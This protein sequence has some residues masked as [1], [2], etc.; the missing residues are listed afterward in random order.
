MRVVDAVELAVGR[1]D[2]DGRDGVRG[3]AVLA[4][5]P[6]HAAAERVA[7]DADVGRRAVQGDEAVLGRG[8]DDL[9]P[10]H[11]RADARLL[12][13]DVDLDVA[14]RVHANQDGIGEVTE[15][16]D[17]VTGALRRDAQ[18]VGHG[19]A[20]GGLHVGG[21]GR[22]RRSARAAG[23]TATF[24]GVRASSQ[25]SSPGARTE[26]R[27]AVRSAAISM[28]EVVVVVAMM[29]LACVGEG[30]PPASDCETTAG[31]RRTGVL[32]CGYP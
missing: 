7:G 24:Q 9:F 15:R 19:E 14:Q 28:L 3:Q 2:L 17:A 31:V 21:V 10:D 6:A 29:G 12:C 32:R 27:T 5:Q 16:S 30:T 18:A 11:A 25:P 1:D 23:R 8:V 20:D 4:R 22:A 13:L 26:P